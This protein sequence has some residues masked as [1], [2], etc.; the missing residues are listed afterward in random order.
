MRGFGGGDYKAAWDGDVFTFFD[1]SKA[2]G[3]WTEAKLTAGDAAIAHIEYYP[4]VSD[5][6]RDVKGGKFVGIKADKQEVALGTIAV[7]PIDGWNSV[8]VKASGVDV[9][10]VKFEAND[11]SFGN[12]GE[13][14]LYTKC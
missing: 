9:A 14:K 6:G 3:G 5:L 2:D 8:T 1:F 11:G 4:R 13:V 7:S 12:I 10:G